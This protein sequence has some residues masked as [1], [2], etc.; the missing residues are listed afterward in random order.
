MKN[1]LYFI[2]VYIILCSS[3]VFA[4]DK[5]SIS[6]QQLKKECQLV[7]LKDF[8]KSIELANKGIELSL[9]EKD[10]ISYAFF[11]RFLGTSYYF[12]GDY[13]KA[14]NYYFN[15]IKVLENN[16]GQEELG[17]SYNELA[18]LYRKT[19]KLNLAK[20]TYDKA[21][22]IFTELSDSTYISMI[23]NE[24]G[25]VYEYEGDYKE[26][27]KRYTTSF[28]ISEKLNDSVA[29]SYALNNIAGLY[30]LQNKFNVAQIYF[31]KALE[32]RKLLNDSFA[33]AINYSDL[34]SNS[35]ASQKYNEAIRYADSSNIIAE[36]LR[37]IELQS[38]NYLTLSKTY[39]QL[40]NIGSAYAYYKKYIS[41]K[42][43]I[44]TKE[45]ENQ[46]NEL[47]TK[48]QT[49]KK[50]LE[51]AK[52][53]AE[54]INEK[55]KRYFTYGALVFF[56]LLFAIAIWAFKQK[57]KSATLLQSKNQLLEKANYL[58][59]HQKEELSEKQKEI[60]DSIN[61]AK[62][63]QNA[64]LANEELVLENLTEHFILFKP[65]DIVSGDFTWATKKDN[66]FYLACCDSTGHGVPGAFM[67]LL[68][69]G[70]LSEAIKER[71]ISE[72]GKIFDYV[73]ARLIETIGHDEQKDGFDGILVCMDIT[74][75]KISYAAANNAPILIYNKNINYLSANKMPVGEGIK[76][77]DFTTFHI[78]Y[79]KGSTLYLYTDG[80]PD[81][82]GGEKGKKFKY[83]QL[84]ELLSNI[85]DKPIAF[86]KEKL[87]TT[88]EN[89]RGNLEQ[90]DDV[91]IIGITL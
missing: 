77:E 70:F 60:V 63:I 59:T 50:D 83:K 3:H 61:Y 31:S 21:L 71:N 69:I 43:S 19:R 85:S 27:L 28:Q 88:F 47:N 48:Y 80:Y 90:V 18:K 74:T 15:S 5:G 6:I 32:I 13:L 86:Q 84:E 23:N 58:I 66:L 45:S 34:A 1:I 52:N 9:K 51:L 22:K 49:E 46:L 7:S 16:N 82:F 30:S 42:D 35:I 12:K 67:S 57:K 41:L 79:E 4:Q 20:E 72:P 24:S 14:S 87:D 55:N 91:C 56:I 81:Q 38:Q 29:V 8:D 44:F 68:N 54:I 64:L 26:A 11:E 37:Y 40:G 89:W 53:K 73:R 65:K 75:K 62:K 78:N 39:D 36:N 10:S 33:L 2:L 76:T 17:F 25:V